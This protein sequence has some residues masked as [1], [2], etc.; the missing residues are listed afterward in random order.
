MPLWRCTVI[1]ENVTDSASAVAELTRPSSHRHFL[2]ASWGIRTSCSF[3][4]PFDTSS[5]PIKTGTITAQPFLPGNGAIF[6]SEI[7][8]V[9]HTA[10]NSRAVRPE[11]RQMPV[12]ALVPLWIADAFTYWQAECQFCFCHS[13]SFYRE[14][15][16]LN[17][18]T[19]QSAL[20]YQLSV[21]NLERF[22]RKHWHWSK[23]CI[24]DNSIKWTLY[25]SSKN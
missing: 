14:K 23:T 24:S 6:V 10:L 18:K 19:K 25:I 12:L 15:A 8:A 5:L 7:R 2:W 3:Y 22:H 11:T 13:F 16:V 17:E 4:V 9:I 21:V 20:S 1:A